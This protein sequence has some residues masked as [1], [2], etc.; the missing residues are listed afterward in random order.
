MLSVQSCLAHSNPMAVAHQA[1]LSMGFFRQEHWNGLPFPFPMHES[2]KWKWS[3]SVVSE[4]CLA[5]S[6]PMACSAPGSSV[7]GDSPGKNTGVGCHALLQGIFPTQGSNP[8]LSRLQPWQAAPFPLA[9]PGK[10]NYRA[11][12]KCWNSH[13]RKDNNGTDRSQEETEGIILGLSVSFQPSR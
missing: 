3:C 7:H 5:L 1:P 6:N 12:Y 2:E 10:P 8:R 11:S 4:S 13:P 9:P